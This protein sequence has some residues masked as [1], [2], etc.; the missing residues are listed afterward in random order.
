MGSAHVQREGAPLSL[1]GGKVGRS[2]PALSDVGTTSITVLAVGL[3]M[4]GPRGAGLQERV[5]RDVRMGISKDA[6][7][8]QGLARAKVTS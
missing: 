7:L 3:G 5:G 1:V 4:A 8:K 6:L 2:L